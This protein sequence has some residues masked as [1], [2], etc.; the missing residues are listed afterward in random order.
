MSERTADALDDATEEIRELKFQK[1]VMQDEL[2][3]YAM[4]EALL[5]ECLKEHGIDPPEGIGA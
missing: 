3:R 2:T 1:S 4:R 5:L